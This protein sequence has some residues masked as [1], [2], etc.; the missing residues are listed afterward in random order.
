MVQAL[1]S[2]FY[3]QFDMLYIVERKQAL[4]GLNRIIVGEFG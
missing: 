4:K 2:L 3:K 1:K